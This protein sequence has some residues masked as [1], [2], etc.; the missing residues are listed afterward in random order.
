MSRNSS[1]VE[2]KMMEGVERLLSD[3]VYLSL[4]LPRFCEEAA[5]YGRWDSD[6]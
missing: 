3:T 2:R 1:Q 6:G 4:D 5:G